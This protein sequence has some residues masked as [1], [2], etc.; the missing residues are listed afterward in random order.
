MSGARKGFALLLA[1]PVR[2]DRRGRPELGHPLG[3]NARPSMKELLEILAVADGGPQGRPIVTRRATIEAA[4]EQLVRQCVPRFNDEG[5][6][7]RLDGKRS[8]PSCA[9]RR[10]RQ[11]VRSTTANDNSRHIR[12]GRVDHL[13]GL[14]GEGLREILSRLAWASAIAFCTSWSVS[15]P[16]SVVVERL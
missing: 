8:I 9:R 13:I 5:R 12:P 11:C 6:F 16:L 10:A 2:I 15:R 1:N 7:P 14:L 4:A 3:G